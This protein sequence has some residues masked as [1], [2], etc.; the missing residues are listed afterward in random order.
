[1]EAGADQFQ[2][3]TTHLDKGSVDIMVTWSHL[4]FQLNWTCSPSP[5]IR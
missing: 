2:E 5:K 3:E 1:M 4:E